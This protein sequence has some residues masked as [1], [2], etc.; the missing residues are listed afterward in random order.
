[1]FKLKEG[2]RRE[3][4][5]KNHIECQ[6]VSFT[7]T[8]VLCCSISQCIDNGQLVHIKTNSNC[9]PLASYGIVTALQCNCNCCSKS[10]EHKKY[11]Q[12]QNIVHF[13]ALKMPSTQ[14]QPHNEQNGDNI[15]KSGSDKSWELCGCSSV[16]FCIHC[17]GK[18]H[19]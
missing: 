4:K 9:K 5:E 8:L 7:R 1:M 19:F 10:G 13:N 17:S 14:M 18:K 16:W 2:R 6:D 15:L 11:H 3:K 12:K